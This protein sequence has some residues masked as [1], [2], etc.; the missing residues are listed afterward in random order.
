MTD[1]F[2]PTT[3]MVGT[4]IVVATTEDGSAALSSPAVI[5]VLRE[6]LEQV[7]R[8]GFTSHHDALHDHAEIAQ[9]ALAYLCAG[10]AMEIGDSFAGE[11]AARAAAHLDGAATIWPYEREMFRPTGYAECLIK[12]AAMLIAEADRAI[13]ARG[14]FEHIR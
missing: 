13:V 12:A 8:H 5:A 6:R 10:L 4:P 2:T 9:G 11:D 3:I 1:A 14:L 7:E